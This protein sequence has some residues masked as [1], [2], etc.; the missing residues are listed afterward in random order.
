VLKW[1]G[2]AWGPADVRNLSTNKTLRAVW[3]TGP[4]DLW[5]VGDQAWHY[6]GSGW[7]SRRSGTYV[8]LW[9]AGPG[10][11][12]LASDQRDLVR[13]NG[14]TFTVLNV[15]PGANVRSLWG[16]GP[17]DMWMVGD[18]GGIWHW[19]GVSLSTLASG[20]DYSLAAVWGANASTLWAFG[21]FGTVLRYRP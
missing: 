3:G 9:G 7:T 16:T 21:P 5:A 4:T 8:A 1:N 20:A 17:A 19:N 14:S 6:D 11:L 2:T 18:N 13:W 12:W 10:D 15:R